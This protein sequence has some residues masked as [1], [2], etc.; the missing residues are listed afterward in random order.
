MLPLWIRTHLPLNKKNNTIQSFWWERKISQ[1]KK[2]TKSGNPVY[3]SCG[4]SNSQAWSGAG[5]T[6]ILRFPKCRIGTLLNWFWSLGSRERMES[7]HWRKFR[8]KQSRT[9][10]F[11]GIRQQ[12]SCRGLGDSAS[13]VLVIVSLF[14]GEQFVIHEEDAIPVER[15]ILMKKSIASFESYA[16]VI[17]GEEFNFLQMLWHQ[18]E[19]LFGCLPNRFV[20]DSNIIGYFWY[21][22]PRIS[23]KPLSDQHS[24]AV[25]SN[26]ACFL[27]LPER[28]PPWPSSFYRLIVCETVPGCMPT[29]RTISQMRFF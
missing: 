12:L 15:C 26:G 10:D 13:V 29:V 8:H 27:P 4:M 2:E 17:A 9:E 21:W 18:V 20:A 25:G 14:H 24:V 1:L 16:L 7:C 3:E 11:A 28:Y 23:P 19:I 22:D 5:H 6:K